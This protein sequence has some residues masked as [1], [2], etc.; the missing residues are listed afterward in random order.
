VRDVKRIPKREAGFSYLIALFAL[1]IVSILSV[2]ALENSLTKAR[3]DKE[4]ELL[5]VGNAYR[6]AIRTYYDKTPGTAKQYPAGLA[7][8]LLDDRT[9]TKRRPLRRLYR[10]PVTG[11]LEW[12]LVLTEDG[13]VKG[14]YSLSRD[15]P[16]KVSGFADPFKAFAGAKTYQDWVFVYQTK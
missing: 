8:L 15:R 14:V 10:D 4:A 3:R 5:F 12:G 13:K 11:A 16:I 6:E 7:S 2:R 9:T 1:A